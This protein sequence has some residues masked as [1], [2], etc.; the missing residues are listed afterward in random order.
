MFDKGA[1]LCETGAFFSARGGEGGGKGGESV[2]GGGGGL[3]FGRVVVR[4][5]LSK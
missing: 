1:C 4:S 2:G 5:V 3:V